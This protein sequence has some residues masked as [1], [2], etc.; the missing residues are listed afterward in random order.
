MSKSDLHKVH[1]VPPPLNFLFNIP[2]QVILEMKIPTLNY[3]IMVHSHKSWGWSYSK[4]VASTTSCLLRMS[5]WGPSFFPQ[6][7]ISSWSYPCIH[8]V[9]AIT[10]TSKLFKHRLEKAPSLCNF[11]AMLHTSCN[12]HPSRDA[13]PL[14]VED[15]GA[16]F[17][18][19]LGLRIVHHGLCAQPCVPLQDIT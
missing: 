7:C 13:C 12:L 5:S 1:W 8:Y 16:F 9:E 14:K 19:N 17:F 10:P 18:K 2:S 3:G 15:G 6:Q 4:N 11:G